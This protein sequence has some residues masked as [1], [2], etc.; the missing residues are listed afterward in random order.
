MFFSSQ[1]AN[2]FKALQAISLAKMG[3]MIMSSIT[4]DY[5][6][7]TM[8][9]SYKVTWQVGWIY[10]PVAGQWSIR[11]HNP[12]SWTALSPCKAVPAFPHG[13]LLL[14]SGSMPPPHRGP[15]WPLYLQLTIT[16]TCT[17]INIGVLATA[18]VTQWHSN[19]SLSISV[20]F[21]VWTD[22]F[23]HLF[24]GF[25]IISPFTRNVSKDFS[26]TFLLL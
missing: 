15:L 2:T 22:Y 7:L 12:I 4:G 9:G 16:I 10:N 1:V 21:I 13:C 23:I 5:T 6:P 18:H 26:L 24:V 20:L 17:S 8:G 25:V 3:H 19:N 11:T 14:S